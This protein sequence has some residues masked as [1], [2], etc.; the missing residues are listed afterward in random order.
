[1]SRFSRW[2]DHLTDPSDREHLVEDAADVA[3]HLLAVCLSVV[4]L[5]VLYVVIAPF[6]VTAGDGEL[7]PVSGTTT[8]EAQP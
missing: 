6:V 7:A 5:V 1:M 4:L 8:T 2:A 3:R